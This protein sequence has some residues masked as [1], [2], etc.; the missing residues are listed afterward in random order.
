LRGLGFEVRTDAYGAIRAGAGLLISS[1]GTQQSEPAGDNAAGIALAAQL[2]ILGESFSKAA[3]TH[4]TV[5][6]AGHVGSLK[7]NQSGSNDEAA[8]FKALH[9][10]LSGMVAQASAEAAQGDVAQRNTSTT[11]DKLPHTT[12]PVI[13]IAA[14]AGLAQT[15][16]QDIQLSAQDT[17]TLASG[18]DTHIA[19]GGAHRVHTG[20]A[21]GVLGGAIKPGAEAAGKGLTMIAA[22][23]DIEFQ[24]QAGPVQIAAKDMVSIMSALQNAEFMSAKA[25]YFAVGGGARITIA[26]GDIICECPGTITV[27][28]TVKEFLAGEAV[29]VA[30]PTLP[31]SICV[32]CM[33]NAAKYGTPFGL[34]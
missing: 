6:L 21:I 3:G 26:N 10:S 24:A 15:A 16:G 7:A 12:D 29:W 31:S 2:K 30:M 5:K 18:Q 28:A 11:G 23:G 8:P 19:T 27:K 13:A 9:T 25:I 33:L 20:Q 17:I 22:Q 14:K 34:K 4:Q 1:Y 32:S